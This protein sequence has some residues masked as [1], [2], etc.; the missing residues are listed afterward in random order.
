MITLQIFKENE[1]IVKENDIDD[2]LY[3][4]ESGKVKVHTNL[5]GKEITLAYLSKGDFFGEMALIDEKPRSA[6]VSALETTTLKVF[7]RNNFLEILKSDSDVG[8]KFLSGLFNRLRDSNSKLI[9][10]VKDANIDTPTK[11][12]DY[13]ENS[14]T[15]KMEGLTEKAINSLP[16]SPFKI[17]YFP[18]IIGR[19]SS[20][21]F[22][23]KNLEIED[24]FPLQISRHHLSIQII[25]NKL[26]IFDV[27]ST[28]GIE[29]D[30]LRIGGIEKENGPIEL[31]KKHILIIG[32]KSS[33]FRYS[34][35]II[36][37]WKISYSRYI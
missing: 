30:S 36:R 34:L 28:L 3:L 2:H 29:I 22:S 8:T 23:H 7:H 24:N 4:I 19:K 31:D 26:V 1:I 13:K 32:D 11:E 37:Q 18:F 33:D 20:D 35:N 25:N 27:G 21:P 14:F 15:I 10:Y 5:D 16:N 6:S 9:Q 12:I 17:D